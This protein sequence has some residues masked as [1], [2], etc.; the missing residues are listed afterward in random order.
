MNP[1]KMHGIIYRADRKHPAE[2]W[3]PASL[4]GH[5]SR[6]RSAQP[7]ATHPEEEGTTCAL[8]KIWASRD[9]SRPP[10]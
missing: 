10:A 8:A 2:G 3:H 1:L 9:E 5:K 7:D 6:R 4:A